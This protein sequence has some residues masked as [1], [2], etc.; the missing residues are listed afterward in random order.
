MQDETI[1]MF[2][3]TTVFV[4]LTTIWQFT[5]S[6]SLIE[7]WAIENS[8]Q[9]LKQENRLLR[10]GPFFWTTTK[11]Q[12]VYYV[13]LLDPQGNKRNAWVRCGSFWLGVLS[14]DVEIQWQD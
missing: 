14:D 9:I 10:R 13:L 12:V 8:Y 3:N 11:G 5:K 1:L 4:V 2:L 7:N 6:D